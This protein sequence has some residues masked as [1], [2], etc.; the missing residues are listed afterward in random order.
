MCI[1]F[2]SLVL[3]LGILAFLAPLSSAQSNADRI[4]TIQTNL[5]NAKAAFDQLPD[6]VKRAAERGHRRVAHLADVVDRLAPSLA[7]GPRAEWQEPSEG[8]NEGEADENGLV[9]VNNPI[10]DFRFSPFAG[11]TQNSAVTARCG[12]SVVVGFNDS[13]SIL[14]TLATGT[15]GVSASGYATS[16]NGGESFKDR[17]AVPPGPDVNSILAGRPS[18]ACS[19]SSHFYLAQDILAQNGSAFFPFSGIALSISNDGGAIW[20]DPIVVITSPPTSSF[21]DV[22]DDP[23]VAVDPS[24][25]QRVYVSYT[26]QQVDF[27]SGNIC[28]VVSTVEVLASNDGGHTFPDPPLVLDTH[29]WNFEDTED[30]GTRMAVSSQGTVYVAWQNDVAIFALNDIG[31]GFLPLL[32]VASFTPGGSPTA[33]VL[34]DF[35]VPG[36]AE[37][38]ERGSGFG[39]FLQPVPWFTGD[40]IFKVRPNSFISGDKALQGGFVNLHGFDLMVDRSGGPSD[41]KLY[42]AWDD[43]RNGFAAAPE[44]EANSL[45]IPFYS[46][47]DILFTSSSDGG[48]TFAPT[49]QVNSDLQP[50]TARGHDHFRPALAVDRKGKV[51]ACWYDRRNDPQNFQFERFCAESADAGANW[52]EFRIPGSL[53]T[54]NRGQDILIPQNDMGLNDNLTTDFSGHASGF[55]GGFQWMSS[56]MN[57]DIKSVKFR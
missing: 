45:D 48:Q 10:R 47:T 17:G 12:E 4:K 16:H 33:P 19:D 14:D 38:F 2:R 5:K 40:L 32:E 57:P 13:G 51:A 18:V 8:W 53:S 42:I 31:F 37:I 24:N 25:H 54:P 11:F 35:V 36:G 43:A 9:P 20:G 27:F 55:L 41:G 22:F 34:V 50:T 29:C 30:V 1:R 3:S 28:G 26:H 6:D 52:T 46:F 7:K 39:S 21:P 56:G 23:T 44:F 49:R 15:G